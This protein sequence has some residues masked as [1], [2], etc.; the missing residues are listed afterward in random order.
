[1]LGKEKPRSIKYQSNAQSNE[2]GILSRKILYYLNTKRKSHSM[3]AKMD[4]HILGPPDRQRQGT[5]SIYMN[6]NLNHRTGIACAAKKKTSIVLPAWSLVLRWNMGG[7]MNQSLMDDEEFYE[8][9]E[10][11]WII[12]GWWELIQKKDLMIIGAR[13]IDEEPILDGKELLQGIIGVQSQWSI[14]YRCPSFVPSPK[15]IP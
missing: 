10:W 6:A 12:N 11:C 1:M 7:E 8:S 2:F 5:F 9:D 14:S 15:P 13:H 3:C 4:H